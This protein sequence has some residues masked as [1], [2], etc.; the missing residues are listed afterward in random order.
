[1]VLGAVGRLSSVPVSFR[2]AAP[3]VSQ[4]DPA[5]AETAALDLVTL[6]PRPKKDEPVRTSPKTAAAV[7]TTLTFEVSPTATPET[8]QAV[9]G[10]ALG[11]VRS[12]KIKSENNHTLSYDD[13]KA[14]RPLLYD[15]LRG[16]VTK[17]DSAAEAI[18]S[19]A[20]LT[21]KLK[22]GNCGEHARVAYQYLREQGVRDMALV[23]GTSRI[24][25]DGYPVPHEFV[26]LGL[27]PDAD[28]ADPKTWGERA[29]ILDGWM[30][31][32]KGRPVGFALPA[33]EGLKHIDRYF[34]TGYGLDYRLEDSLKTFPDDE[35]LRWDNL[36]RQL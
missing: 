33:A 26:V 24:T 23:V 6:G 10:E 1:M 2:A 13:A 7:P 34:D 11:F 8:T 35:P 15:E 29:V 3:V 30:N 22:V 16:S 31:V 9:A 21:R 20:E 12:L 14:I 18:A 28:L 25:M 36:R 17:S 27:D 5:P 4:D 32:E 19:Y